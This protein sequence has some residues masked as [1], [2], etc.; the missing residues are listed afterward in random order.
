MSQTDAVPIDEAVKSEVELLE[1]LVDALR[2]IIGLVYIQDRSAHGRR[3]RQGDKSRNS[4]GNGDGKG[5]LPIQDTAHT[6]Q[7]TDRYE[8]RRQYAGNADNR[9]LYVAHG[10][11]RRLPRPFG[12]VLDFVFDGFDDDDSIIDEQADSQNHGKQGQ[13]VDREIEDFE[14]GKCPQQRY[15]YGNERNQ[16]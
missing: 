11:N 9:V 4:N 8:Y 12:I 16:S 6:A 5:K 3:Q 2:V 15:W 14:A 10:D 7:E 1:K 13:R